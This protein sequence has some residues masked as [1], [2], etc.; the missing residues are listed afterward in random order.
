[1]QALVKKTELL[2]ALPHNIL[3]KRLSDALILHTLHTLLSLLLDLLPDL[4]VSIHHVLVVTDCLLLLYLLSF[5]EVG[6]IL[7]LCLGLKMRV[8]MVQLCKFDGFLC[9]LKEASLSD[10]KEFKGEYAVFQ[11]FHCCSVGDYIN[12]IISNQVCMF[13]IIQY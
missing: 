13:P 6:Q 8:V 3:D 4:E 7:P 10:G 12:N 5:V 9:F 2:E 11:D 1:M